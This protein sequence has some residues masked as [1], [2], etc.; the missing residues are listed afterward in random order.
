MLLLFHEILIKY[1]SNES[2]DYMSLLAFQ[3][4][5]GKKNQQSLQQISLLNRS[6]YVIYFYLYYHL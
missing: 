5:Y 1:P 6:K 4:V 3:L 2:S